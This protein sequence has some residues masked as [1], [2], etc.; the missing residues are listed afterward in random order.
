[1]NPALWLARAATRT[2]EAPALFHGTDLVATY[3]ALDRDAAAIGA[4]LV[5]KGIGPGDRVAIFLS[6]SPEFL[7]ILFGIWYVGATAVPIN[8][9]LHPKEVAYILTAS[10]A[11][12]AFVKDA[13]AFPEASIPL[14]EPNGDA[15]SAVRA[16]APL[17]A[18][19]VMNPDDTLWLFYTSGTTGRPKGAQLTGANLAAMSL[20]YLADVDRVDPGDAALYAAP[21]SHGAGL[22]ALV[23]VLMGARHVIP[24]SGGFDPAEIFDLA[25]HHN[26]VSMFAAPTMVKRMVEAARVTGT[27]G[28]GIKTVVYGGGPMYVADIKAALDTFGPKFVQIYGQGEAPMAITALSREDIAE[29]TH[30]DWDRRLA[31]V[32]RAQSVGAIAILDPDGEPLPPGETGE[33]AVKGPIVMAGY[34]DAPEANARAFR[35]GWLLTGDV[36]HLDPDGYLTLH[37]R[38]KDMIISGGSNIYPREVEEALLTHPGVTE[39]SVVGEAHPEWGEIVVAFVVGTATPEDLDATCTASI[40]R[41]KKPK[42]YLFVPELPKNNYGKVLKTELRAMLEDQ[43]GA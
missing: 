20:A 28:H 8:A 21:M 15:F 6:N 17:D 4:G 37:D 23:H 19:Q 29:S 39:V 33:I 11:G 2:P 38:A 9:K 10:D 36:G 35:D 22:Y 25:A 24:N 13:D 27:T 14:I 40:A 12:L 30:P 7:P 16:T 18:P 42:R 32:G 3:S 41:F 31:S 43:R 34:L 1:M 26:N 5:A